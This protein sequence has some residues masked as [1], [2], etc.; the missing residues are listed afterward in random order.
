MTPADLKAAAGLLV[1]QR[2]KAVRDRKTHLLPAIDAAAWAVQTVRDAM[3]EADSERA[4][5]QPTVPGDFRPTGLY[6]R[7]F[8]ATK[9]VP[10]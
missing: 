4:P 8:P 6:S 5:L 2:R 7:D 10:L 3:A 1:V 9:V